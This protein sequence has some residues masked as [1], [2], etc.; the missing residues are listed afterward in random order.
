[1]VARAHRHSAA[2]PGLDPDRNRRLRPRAVYLQLVLTSSRDSQT[3]LKG[4]SNS[5]YLGYSLGEEWMRD[6][7]SLSDAFLAGSHG[8]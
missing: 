7:T 1:M 6:H 8:K 3:S 4:V 5:F 2:D